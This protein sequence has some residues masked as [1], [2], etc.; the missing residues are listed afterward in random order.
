MKNSLFENHLT[1]EWVADNSVSASDHSQ[2]CALLCIC[3]PDQSQLFSQRRYFNQIPAFRWFVK[4]PAGQL[5]AHT[6][7]HIKDIGYQSQLITVGGIAEVCVHPLYRKKGWV[8]RMLKDISD[9][10]IRRHL[11]FALLLGQEFVYRSSGFIKAQNRMRYIDAE[12]GI[13]MEKKEHDLMVKPLSDQHWDH[14]CLVD[15]NG[16][17]F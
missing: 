7:L 17:L 15:L 9:W 3:F 4:N 2:L 5:V 11:P 13:P 14:E 10:L 12:T 6:A 16:P 1:I 8:K